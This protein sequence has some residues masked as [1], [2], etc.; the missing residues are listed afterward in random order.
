[1]P[2]SLAWL[3]SKAQ[4]FRLQM[5]RGAATC[6]VL[7]PTMCLPTSWCHLKS[8]SKQVTAATRSIVRPPYPGVWRP[9]QY[10]AD[11]IDCP[12]LKSLDRSLSITLMVS[13]WS[14]CFVLFIE[15]LTS[16]VSSFCFPSTDSPHEIQHCSGPRLRVSA[17]DDHLPRTIPWWQIPGPCSTVGCW[18]IDIGWY[19][20]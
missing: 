9:L 4:G 18:E 10:A 11:A 14:S 6:N 15:I 7:W 2:E 5:V 16:C 17:V 3:S 8:W 20:M 12:T 19:W 13:S 1:M